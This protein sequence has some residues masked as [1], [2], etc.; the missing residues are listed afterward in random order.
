MDLDELDTPAVLVDLDVLERNIAR[1]AGWAAERGVR[2]RPHAKTHKTLEIAGMQL[3]S[4][5]CGLSVAKAGEAEVFA[6]AGFRDLFVAYP[7]VGP[8]K[9]R[10]LVALA[11]DSRLAVGVDS[12]EGAGAVAEAFKAA[13]RRVDVLL[14]V[15]VGFHRVGVTPAE[16]LR[17]ALRIGELPGL[18][19]R[20]FFTHAGQAYH[21][22]SAEAVAAIGA[23]EGQILASVAAEARAAGLAIE[24]VSPGSTPTAPHV[25]AVPG[26]TECRPG[27]YVFHDATQVGLGVCSQADCALTVLATI[28]SVSGRERAVADAGS[29][30]LSSDPLRPRPE[31][32]GLLVGR[33]SRLRR[34]SEEHGVID[35]EDGEV[36]Q[37]GEHVR[38]VP[39]HSCVVVN[40]HDRLYGVRGQRVEAVLAVAARGMIQ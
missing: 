37:V 5:A 16:A 6:R 25:M 35:V 18:N 1:M 8:H 27:N 24:E 19:L 28:A 17:T 21:Q 32:H 13:N 40:L 38:I 39:N 2:L 36:F 26:V 23:I 33:R 3:A 10:R 20:G 15:D 34:L 11:E 31:G 7:V 22:E 30:T 14:K 29:K 4:G 9:L 12:I